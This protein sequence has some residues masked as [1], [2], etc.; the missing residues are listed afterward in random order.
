[1]LTAI[2]AIIIFSLLITVH[3]FGHFI[4]AKKAGITVHEFSIGMGKAIWQ[5]HKNGTVYSVRILPI[6]GF[7]KME[8][9]DGDSTD[10]GA[11]CN[12][13]AWKRFIVLFAG[14][15]MNIITGFILFTLLL[16]LSSPIASTRIGEVL[17]EYPFFEA[18]IQVGDRIVRLE[19]ENYST[20]VNIYADINFFKFRNGDGGVN[21][22]FE[23]DGE[24]FTKYIAQ[25]KDAE[26]GAYIFGFVPMT[27][28]LG[29]FS[30]IK[31]AFYQSVFTVKMVV[32]SFGMLIT[33]RV[34][35]SD[36]SGPV[37]IVKEIGSAAKTGILNV[38]NLAALLSINLG[39]ANLLP[40]P[41][42]DGGRILFL[43]VEKIRRKPLKP[44]HE[45]MIH[46]IGF[47]LL[48]LLMVFVTF[49][50]IMRIFG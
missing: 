8:G 9:E 14:A 24:K 22:T 45:G 37:G 2:C 36:M 23:R 42:L 21:I 29:I 4:T 49:G 20:N 11:F 17:P 47:A 35:V 32:E 48:M 6:G 3:E 10:D 38:I 18:G 25:K 44:E 34:P 19:G 27:E 33:G 46:F 28:T 13:S 30:I 16:S 7:C 43:I 26:T 31:N 15:F 50:D 39:V 40:I 41:A 1:M 12:K 5:K